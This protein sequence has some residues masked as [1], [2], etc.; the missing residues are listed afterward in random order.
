MLGAVLMLWGCTSPESPE[1]VVEDADAMLYLQAG[2]QPENLL[3]PEYLLMPDF[4]LDQHGRIPDTTVVGVELTTRLD[5]ETTLRRC[6]DMLS[7]NGWKMTGEEGAEHAFRL[8]VEKKGDLME[9]R[10]VQGSGP[11]QLFILYRPNARTRL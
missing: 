7:S 11:T 5:L 4:E 6:H 9:I 3:F 10:A 2:L 8:L 1:V